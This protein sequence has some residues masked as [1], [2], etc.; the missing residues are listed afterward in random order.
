MSHCVNCG[1]RVYRSLCTNCHEENFIEQQYID[2]EETIP[3]QIYKIARENER[4]IYLKPIDDNK[5]RK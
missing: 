5:K 4:D 3:K 1:E 2:L